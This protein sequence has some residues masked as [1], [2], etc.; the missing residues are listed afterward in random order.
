MLGWREWI[1]ALVALVSN[2][3]LVARTMGYMYL[4]PAV[5]TS[6]AMLPDSAVDD[7]PPPPP[8]CDVP[9]SIDDPP[10]P[11]PTD[12]PPP[13]P[14]DL[15]PP[16]PDDPLSDDLPPPPPPDESYGA[17]EEYD[18]QYTTEEYAAWYAAYAAAYAAGQCD[19]SHYDGG[20][21]ASGE[22]VG[23]DDTHA[24]ESRPSWLQEIIDRGEERT[25]SPE[26][27][28]SDCEAD[29][30]VASQV[31]MLLFPPH[32]WMEPSTHSHQAP[33]GLLSQFVQPL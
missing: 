24:G 3:K 9:A 2:D 16:P 28:T 29:D 33:L 26:R 30:R 6:S 4:V 23:N 27:N 12:L 1:S 31:R 13:P 20:T 8:P 5:L 15:P 14:D 19:P 7:D 25:P 21:A 18:A 32:C 10:P 22:A 11:P 17:E